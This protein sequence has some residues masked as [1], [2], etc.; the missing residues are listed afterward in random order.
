VEEFPDEYGWDDHAAVSSGGDGTCRR[1]HK[2]TLYSKVTDF[3]WEQGIWKWTEA[4]GVGPGDIDQTILTDDEAQLQPNHSLE[5]LPV[6]IVVCMIIIS[7]LV[8]HASYLVPGVWLVKMFVFVFVSK[9]LELNN[10][11]D[12]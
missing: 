2:Y 1:L 11:Y 6:G 4:V 12:Q 5:S 3:E 8:H 10:N 7:Y 9:R